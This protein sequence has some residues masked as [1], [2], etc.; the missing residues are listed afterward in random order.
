MVEYPYSISLEALLLGEKQRSE[1]MFYY[2]KLDD[3]IPE[4]HLLRL[5]HKYVDFSFIRDRVKHLYSHTGRP[6]IDPEVLLRM[7]LIGYLY[8]IRSERRLCDEVKMHLGY[9]WFVGLS[10]QDKVPDHSTFSKNRHERFVENDLFQHIF[11]EIIS[12]CISHRFIEGK[13]LTVD[14]TNIEADA[15]FKSLEPIV[16]ELKP[17]EY[18]EVLEKENPIDD[19]PYE[20]GKDYPL[21]GQKVSND[22]HRSQ[23]DPDAKLSRKSSSAATQLCHS[24]TYIMDNKSRI[25]LEADVANPDRRRD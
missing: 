25:I 19:T 15:S 12:Q 7:L 4:D 3:L 2:I 20:P 5:I 13:H 23:T 18:I 16:V 11:D 8:G 1:P 21:K 6:S 14:A 9:R 10:L 17:K 22:T 24:A